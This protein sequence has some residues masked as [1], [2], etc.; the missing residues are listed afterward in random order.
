LPTLSPTER[1]FV[2]T[3][4]AGPAGGLPA[5]TPARERKRKQRTCDKFHAYLQAE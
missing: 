2:E 4:L 5:G 3:E 1:Q